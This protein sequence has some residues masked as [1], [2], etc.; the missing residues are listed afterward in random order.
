VI[1]RILSF[2][3]FHESISLFIILQNVLSQA[4][5]FLLRANMSADF[6]GIPASLKFNKDIKMLPSLS[7]LHIE[8]RIPNNGLRW[9]S[10]ARRLSSSPA[11]ENG[12][13]RNLSAAK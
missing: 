10:S 3:L 1:T 8:Y 6:D 13:D 7:P 9:F 5:H 11:S 12:L 4:K 2:F